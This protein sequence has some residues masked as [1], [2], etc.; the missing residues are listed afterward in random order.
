MNT[1][2]RPTA[3]ETVVS[4]KCSFRVTA[5]VQE[6]KGFVRLALPCVVIVALFGSIVSCE[7]LALNEQPTAISETSTAPYPNIQAMINAALDEALV[8]V[9]HAAARRAVPDPAHVTLSRTLR[10][11]RD[12]NLATARAPRLDRT[13]LA[14]LTEKERQA[15]KDLAERDPDL[16]AK[17]VAV[18]EKLEREYAAIPTIEVTVQPLDEKGDPVGDSYIIASEDGILNL[19]YSVLTAEEFLLLVQAEQERAARGFAIDDDWSHRQWGSG[20]PWP[21]DTVRYFFDTDTTSSSQR[22]W[23]RSAMGRM[24]NGTG[25]RFEEADGPEWW[26]EL[27]HSLS[28]SNDLSI[29]V[30]DVDGSGEATVGRRGRSKLT[31]DPEF[32]TDEPTFNHEMGHVFGLLHE[33]QRYD[34]DDHVRVRPTGSNYQKIRRLREHR[35]LWF[36]WYDEISTTFSTP[37]DFHSVMHYRSK[38]DVITLRSADKS[39]DRKEWVVYRDNNLVWGRENGNTWFSQWD[40][41]TIKRLY[42][43]RPNARPNFAPE[44]TYP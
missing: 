13:S 26:L 3:V 30:E 40:I 12:S 35:F 38:E 2:K 29:L 37:Y 25:M 5:G 11:A 28:M 17:I 41:Y 32:A 19:G 4:L 43:I 36:T 42:S 8:A 44:S 24:R 22:A 23:M 18:V 21:R 20:R 33:H 10:Q 9:S 6:M 16:V 39:K 14:E 31:M 27:W 34:R 1:K 15:L 7:R